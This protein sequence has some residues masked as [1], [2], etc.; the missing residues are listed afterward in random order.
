MTKHEADPRAGLKANT[1]Y[2]PPENWKKL[3]LISA[4]TDKSQ[5]VL[6]SEALAG[7][8]KKYA[9]KLRKAG[10][11][12]ILAITV[13][14]SLAACERPESATYSAITPAGVESPNSTCYGTPTGDQVCYGK[15]KTCRGGTDPVQT[16]LYGGAIVLCQYANYL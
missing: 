14:A 2:Q 6:M 10:L 1:F 8:F 15:A 3:K 13:T 4:A 11:Q 5:Q 9:E 16:D 12:V 7:L